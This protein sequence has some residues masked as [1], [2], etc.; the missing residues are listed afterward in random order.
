MG[1]F[2]VVHF[3]SSLLEKTPYDAASFGS[4]F[5]VLAGVRRVVPGG[6]STKWSSL[7][8]SALARCPPV[9]K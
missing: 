8:V 7:V 5:G 2:I 4:E 1:G 9:P 6:M 3:G